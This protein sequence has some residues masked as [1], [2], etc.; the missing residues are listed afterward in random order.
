VR[1]LIYD[2]KEKL[3]G[4]T[5]EGEVEKGLAEA[6]A[7]HLKYTYGP[8]TMVIKKPTILELFLFEVVKPLYIFLIFSVFFWF[9]AEQYYLF[10]SALF[11]VFLVGVVIN[12]YQM[13]QLSN[14]IFAMA[15]YEV[16]LHVL[17]DG[18]VKEIPSVDVV[19]GDV[20]FLRKPI[21]IPFEGIIL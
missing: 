14:K 17:R 16:P 9:F 20:V 6:Q 5:K 18:T 12:L 21:K 8:G 1:L 19:P 3:K 2:F 11:V 7:Y 10:A 4:L 15:Y 13:V